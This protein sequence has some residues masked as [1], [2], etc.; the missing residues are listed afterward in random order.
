MTLL[1][2]P[3]SRIVV[4]SATIAIASLC[5]LFAHQISGAQAARQAALADDAHSTAQ[6]LPRPDASP[7]VV[8]LFTSEGCSSCPPADA[9]LARLDRDQPVPGANIIVLGEHVDY[10]DYLGWHDRFSSALLTERQRKY[11][12]FF[13]L[14]DIFTPQMVVNGAAQFAGND[15]LGITKAIEAAAAAKPVPLQFTGVEVRR[16]S[17]AFTLQDGPDTPG[18][19]NV[20]AALVD[21]V[22]TTE[23]RSG[24]NGGRTLHHAGVVRALEQHASD[25]R[26]KNLGK[27]PEAPF[28][29]QYREPANLDGMRLV[30][31]VQSKPMG[32]ILGAAQCLLS[33][34]PV[35]SA[36]VRGET[37]L[38]S[39]CPAPA[40]SATAAR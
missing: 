34:A 23:V 22:D 19:L 33:T 17:V 1:N 4:G 35:D 8:E 12:T 38:I 18:S 6:M 10:W 31:F 21:P 25:W 13:N 39:R 5:L 9:L 30:V 27:H 36:A 26:M 2:S 28:T 40:A 24:E 37:A 15:D 32:P 11:Q 29:V 7:V 14:G 16:D 20:Y 3:R